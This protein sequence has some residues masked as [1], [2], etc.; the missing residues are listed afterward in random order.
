MHEVTDKVCSYFGLTYGKLLPQRDQRAQYYGIC[1][2]CKKCITAEHID[3]KN[4]NEKII[5]I[6]IHVLNKPRV[7]LA[8]KT[9]LRTLAH[10]IAHL[11]EWVH[12]P[13]FE[14]FEFDVLEYMRELGYEV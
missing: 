1:W 13:K 3:E 11:K 12:G 2:P 14:D 9:I 7:A 4:C 8:R 10:E 5:Y 6:R